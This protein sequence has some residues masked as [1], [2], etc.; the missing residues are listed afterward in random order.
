MFALL[1][2]LYSI[3]STKKKYTNFCVLASHVNDYL[4]QTIFHTNYEKYSKARQS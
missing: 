1:I 4:N 2:K 3:F